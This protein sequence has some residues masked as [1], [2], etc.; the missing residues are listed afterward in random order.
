MIGKKKRNM[1][2]YTVMKSKLKQLLFALFLC[3]LIYYLSKIE[4]ELY[5]FTA[6]GFL[7]ISVN[8]VLFK[9]IMALLSFEGIH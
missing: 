2:T 8:M 9:L 6:N 5:L 7:I 3:F 1:K 4:I